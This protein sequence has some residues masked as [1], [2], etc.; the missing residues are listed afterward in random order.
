MRRLGV[1]TVAATLALGLAACGSSGGSSGDT[2]AGER[3][4]DL[5]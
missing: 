2:T 3:Q 4:L 5:R 1:L